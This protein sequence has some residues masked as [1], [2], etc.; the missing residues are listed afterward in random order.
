M[1]KSTRLLTLALLACLFA[2]CGDASGPDRPTAAPATEPA[3]P[4]VAAAPANDSP[5][6]VAES[7][8]PVEVVEESTGEAAAEPEPIVL[9]KT[10]TADAA[11]QLQ[12]YREGTHFTKLTTAQ[13]TSSSPD[14]VE[15]AEV[16]WYGCPHCYNFDPI[17]DNWE[18]TLPDDVNLIRLPVMWNPTNAIHARL[19]YT[20]EALGKLDEVHSAIFNELHVNNRMLTNEADI[21]EFIKKFG[22]SEAEFNKTFRSFAV[23]SKLK[24]AKNL[25][26]RYRIQSVPLLVINGKYLTTGDGIKNFDDMLAVAND[27]IIRERLAR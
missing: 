20:V 25:T 21:L 6:P 18:R 23:E 3:A 10:E 17:I 13:G 7:P 19:F 9:A 12:Q 4:A 15:V 16:F 8:R 2:A 26:Q 11:P 22:I 24:R 27:L 5:A 14:A 1:M